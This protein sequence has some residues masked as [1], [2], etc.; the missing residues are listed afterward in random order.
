MLC[1]PNEMSNV[2]LVIGDEK[3]RVSKDVSSFYFVNII[4]RTWLQYFFQILA[5][6]S[7][8]F[9]AMFFQDF[10]EKGK[11]EV[12]IQGVVYEVCAGC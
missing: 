8:V 1:S 2:T 3:M 11:D 7:P 6:H 4:Y 10:A 9:A 12:P 5:I